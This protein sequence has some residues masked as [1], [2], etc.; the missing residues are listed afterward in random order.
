M[1]WF[2]HNYNTY[3]RLLHCGWQQSRLSDYNVVG[4]IQG[5]FKKVPLTPCGWLPLQSMQGVRTLM[6][7]C[8][9][10]SIQL[11]ERVRLSYVAGLLGPGYED[12]CMPSPQPSPQS[13]AWRATGWYM[14]PTVGL[15]FSCSCLCVIYTVL[16]ISRINRMPVCIMLSFYFFMIKFSFSFIF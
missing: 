5:I 10:L 14:E 4:S 16:C 15:P 9:W 3:W 12:P 7:S 11:H 6:Q 1:A 2:F 8:C 13:W